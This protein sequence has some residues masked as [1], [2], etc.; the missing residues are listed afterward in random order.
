MDSQTKSSLKIVFSILFFDLIGFSIIFPLFPKM[1][2]YYLAREGDHLFIKG[3][4]YLVER[5]ETLFS[6]TPSPHTTVVLFGGVLASIYSLLQ[7]LSSPLWGSVSDRWGRKKTLLVTSIGLAASHLLWVFA[8]PFS[9]LLLARFLGGLMSGQIS[10]ATAVIADVTTPQNR[11][12]AMAVA[13]VAFALGFILGPA[14]GGILAQWDLSQSLPILAPWGINPFSL[15]ALFA[16][17]LGILNVVIVAKKLKESV[18]PKSKEKPEEDS[19]ANSTTRQERTANLLVL[20]RGVPNSKANRVNGA[21]FLFICAFSGMEFTLTFL[22][23]ERLGYSSG[24][25]AL[26]FV[27]IG[28]LLALV[29]GSLVRKMIP[30]IGEN[31]MAALGIA[32]SI[33]GLWVVGLAQNTG[34]LYLGLTLLAVGSA[35]IIPSLTGLL[36]LYTPRDIQGKALGIFRSLGALGRVVGPILA[37]ILYWSQGS[38]SPYLWGGIF[39]FFPLALILKCPPPQKKGEL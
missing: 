31:L 19:R 4:F 11:S 39:L 20:W 8:A 1:V 3:F 37:V 27:F 12:A 6:L 14:F 26:M 10:V 13:G 28:I 32:I 34:I 29:Q 23:V 38:S 15:P 21:Y 9:L 17:L 16:S 24:E 18:D 35:M 5:V 7:F 30:K 33:P 22:A 2:S 25:N 36:S